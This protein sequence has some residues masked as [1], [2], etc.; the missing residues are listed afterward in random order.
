MNPADLEGLIDTLLERRIAYHPI[1]ARIT[2]S[3]CAA[4]FL[5]QLYYWSA[6]ASHLEGWVY[7]TAVEWSNETGLSPDELRGARRRLRG[8]ELI[9]ESDA[10]KHFDGI[11]SFDR[12]ACYRVHK[13]ALYERICH[14]NRLPSPV[15][16]DLGKTDTRDVEITKSSSGDYQIELVK[17]DT[18]YTEITSEITSTS[19][20]VVLWEMF[21]EGMDMDKIEWAHH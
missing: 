14:Q 18:L 10:Y 19:T 9:E 17:T 3:A 2:D 16:D 13:K 8:L 7:K 20:L 21:K 6:R 5:S 11:H 4:L 1:F 12:T 15:V